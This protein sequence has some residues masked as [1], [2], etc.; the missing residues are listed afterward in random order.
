MNEFKTQI[1]KAINQSAGW[2]SRGV[3]VVEVTG[4]EDIF[5]VLSG[6]DYEGKAK[7]IDGSWDVWGT[8]DGHE[9]RIRVTLVRVD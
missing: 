5:D 4:D 9:W 2:N 8:E 7:E 1:E 6:I 3:A